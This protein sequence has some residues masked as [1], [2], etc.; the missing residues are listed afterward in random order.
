MKKP[1]SLNALFIPTYGFVT[2]YIGLF[3][4]N[5][6]LSYVDHYI[7]QILVTKQLCVGSPNSM[8]HMRQ[9]AHTAVHP[10]KLPV[11]D[12]NFPDF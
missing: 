3:E 11:A 2:Q 12:T 7:S 4:S 9:Y 1:L 10:Y 8:R 6:L 5:G